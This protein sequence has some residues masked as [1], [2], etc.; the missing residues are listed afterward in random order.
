MNFI[1]TPKVLQCMHFKYEDM[2]IP[3]AR[4]VMDYEFDFCMN[5]STKIEIF[6]VFVQEKGLPSVRKLSN[7]P[8]SSP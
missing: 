1:Y 4:T 2:S 8:N 3:P 7:H 5:I 6:F